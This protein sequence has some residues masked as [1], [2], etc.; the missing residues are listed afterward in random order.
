RGLA[1]TKIDGRDY[2]HA[3][4]FGARAV[5]RV[6]A[7]EGPGLVHAKVTRAYSH[8]AADTQ[9]KYRPADELID[10]AAHDPILV[11]EHELVTGGVL[12]PDDVDRIRAEAK[13]IAT[14]AAHD[15][16]A[17]AR[18]DAATVLDNVYVRPA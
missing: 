11:L 10:E 3:R 8:S 2:F 14:T 13:D 15:A 18:P 12:T 1:V 7:G 4:H 17:A 16:L 5:E 6:R 9:S